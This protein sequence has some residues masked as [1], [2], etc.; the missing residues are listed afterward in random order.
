RRSQIRRRFLPAFQPLEERQLLASII[1]FDPTGTGGAT[2][3]TVLDVIGFNYATGNVLERGAITDETVE[4]GTT[5]DVLYQTVLG[6]INGYH[7]SQAGYVFPS[8]T[9]S[10]GNISLSDDFG[11][12]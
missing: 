12:Q 7:Y 9:P 1:A 8:V 4:V 3:A 5:F 11:N 6:D 10:N 2:P